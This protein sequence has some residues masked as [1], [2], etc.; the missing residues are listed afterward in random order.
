MSKQ[1]TNAKLP[2]I[3][4]ENN[5][6]YDFADTIPATKKVTK[7]AVWGGGSVLPPIEKPTYLT[8]VDDGTGDLAKEDLKVHHRER[9]LSIESD[10]FSEVTTASLEVVRS[11]SIRR[12]S[13]SSQQHNDQDHERKEPLTK[14][15]LLELNSRHNVHARKFVPD[16]KPSDPAKNSKKMKLKKH[17][18]SAFNEEPLPLPK[19]ASRV[20]SDETKFTEDPA[21]DILNTVDEEAGV[22]ETLSIAT[23]TS[24]IYVREECRDTFL[25]SYRHLARE[26]ERNPTGQNHIKAD[27]TE[28]ARSPRSNYM[29]SVVKGNTI[30]VP[31]ILR[32][33]ADPKTLSMAHKGIGDKKALNVIEVIDQLGDLETI[34]FCDNRLTDI[35]LMPLMEKLESLSQLTHLDLSFNKID[36]S[37]EVMIN[38]LI[39]PICRLKVLVLNGADVDD[40]ESCNLFDA[41]AA[42]KSINSLSV[43]N[44][45]I[46]GKETHTIIYEDMI[47]GP[48]SVGN[49][50]KVNTTLTALDLRWNYI[51]KDS[52]ITMMKSLYVNRTLKVLKL[53]NNAL[54]DPPILV[55]GKALK[56]NHTLTELDL[57]FNGL[58]PVSV[59]VLANA[60]IFNDSMVKLDV[61]GNVIGRLGA[62]ALIGAIERL[63]SATRTLSVAFSNCDTEHD[64]PDL[65]DATS[66]N[67]CYKL[68][69]SQPYDQM[70]AEECL[71]LCS[72]KAACQFKS[73]VYN[74]K[75]MNLE[76][77]KSKIN[78]RADLKVA[79][80]TFLQCMSK[81]II[82]GDENKKAAID[83][84]NA[85]IQGLL[86]VLA[87]FHLFI[88]DRNIAIGIIDKMFEFWHMKVKDGKIELSQKIQSMQPGRRTSILAPIS[89][90]MSM[91]SMS[92]ISSTSSSLSLASLA[93]KVTKST[94]KS[95]KKLKDI[96]KAML[97]DENEP[98]PPVAE[99]IP[100]PYLEGSE[101]PILL[102]EMWSYIVFTSLFRYYDKEDN[103]QIN[104][105]Q[106][107]ELMRLIGIEIIPSHAFRMIRELDRNGSGYINEDEFASI[108]IREYCF[109]VTSEREPLVDR[110]TGRPWIIPESGI[111]TMELITTN[112]APSISD[113]PSDEG[114]NRII[115]CMREVHT[116]DEREVLFQRTIGSPYFCLSA[117]QAQLMFQQ[118]GH[119]SN[120]PLELL[121][122]VLAQLVNMD[123]AH[124]F[125]NTNLDEIA[126]FNLRMTIGPIY[127]ILTGAP[128]GHYCLDM[129]KPMHVLAWKKLFALNGAE[130]TKLKQA[131]ISDTSQKGDWSNFR[132]EMC[133]GRATTMTSSSLTSASN[134]KYRCDYVSTSRPVLGVKA[135]SQER[136]NYLVQSLE[137]QNLRDLY[138]HRLPINAS[139]LELPSSMTMGRVKD[140]YA[141]FMETC[142][143]YHDVWPEEK[144][145]DPNNPNRD[146]VG[147]PPTPKDII[148]RRGPK[149]HTTKHHK[150]YPYALYKLIQLQIAAPTLFLSVDQVIE[151][152][153]Y[154]PSSDVPGFIRVQVL[155]ALWNTI[156]DLEH[157]YMILNMF[158]QAEL[159]ETFHRL[160]PL[161]VVDPMYPDLMYLL[162]LRRYEH[163][164]IC[165]I[166]IVL[167]VDEPGEN[168]L[169]QEYRVSYF[170]DPVLGWMLPSTWEV[171]D[172]GK[173]ETGPRRYG[174]LR[175]NYVSEGPDMDPN[176]ELRFELRK[177]TLAGYRNVL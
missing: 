41:I 73:L 171:P 59:L 147:R 175:F 173:A 13:I 100:V 37:S 94:I 8:S 172:D 31:L 113:V 6:D 157:L 38:Y 165:K 72:F 108:I 152:M 20:L 46:G 146:C 5:L 106:F 25:S 110:E 159:Y 144:I 153:S 107:T 124:K 56:K 33:A 136:L 177:R 60:L 117:H 109:M 34:N 66:P 17:S 114:I 125:L 89:R 96:A 23:D 155:T 70:V 137:L 145:K 129:R 39:S 93:K 9:S 40:D 168:W 16:E 103:L 91:E 99:I 76:R 30:P 55:I 132:N 78:M 68:D 69:L 71:Y 4:V 128:T 75:E 121:G 85:V 154:F 156:V 126:R 54:S 10:A 63:P 7:E 158:S 131:G 53:G 167:G 139:V 82:S 19:V 104:G 116:Q 102:E 95:G 88:L 161:N 26:V 83:N 90:N 79:K 77:K 105:H 151:I 133:N 3:F 115:K 92:S 166:C 130:N 86:D 120:P 174:W 176:I 162:D 12:K 27:G 22:S 141:E 50:L 98:P 163:R 134:T 62:Q 118:M 149:P 97:E 1:K 42:N 142:H 15:P 52:A 123:Q 45:L 58:N 48:V 32:R 67:G 21:V 169:N 127:H 101:Y 43:T 84:K 150:T 36:E 81:Y 29:R 138:E 148:A 35:S 119:A 170:D 64:S 80:K 65:F 160:G 24:T 140:A 112:D 47:T 74:G 51:R 135:M 44:N 164:E 57:S 2:A 18:D 28:P 11:A 87:I 122:T 143:H 61:S 49:M 111:L 14:N